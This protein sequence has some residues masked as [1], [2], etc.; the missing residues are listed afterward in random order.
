MESEPQWV[1]VAVKKVVVRVV[2]H[3]EEESVIIE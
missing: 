2:S 1:V 3:G